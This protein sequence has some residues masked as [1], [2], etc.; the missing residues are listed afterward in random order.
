[1]MAAAL[2]RKPPVKL[3][4]KHI[5]R[6]V[7]DTASAFDPARL[8]SKQPAFKIRTPQ[9]RSVPPD[10]PGGFNQANSTSFF[11]SSGAKFQQ[12]RP[13]PS[14]FVLCWGGEN[15]P[16]RGLSLDHCSQRPASQPDAKVGFESELD[17]SRGKSTAQ[18]VA[19]NTH[20]HTHT[21]TSK[22]PQKMGLEMMT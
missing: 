17:P 4:A 10:T 21:Q 16:F 3:P 19:Q 5:G 13:S 11:D 15:N 20:T 6:K 7:K 22:Q 18:P 8:G 9:D 1:M 14:V 12:D 2:G